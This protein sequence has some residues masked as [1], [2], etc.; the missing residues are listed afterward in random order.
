MGIAP[1]HRRVSVHLKRRGFTEYIR[2]GKSHE[3]RSGVI[4]GVRSVNRSEVTILGRS[5]SLASH[6]GV[7]YRCGETGQR[8]A[9]KTEY[10]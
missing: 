10:T 3:I 5:Y 7:S 2:T 9:I 4:D 6:V 8:V 1:P